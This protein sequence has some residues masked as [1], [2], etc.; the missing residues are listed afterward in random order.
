ML[1]LSGLVDAM[2]QEKPV[3]YYVFMD[4]TSKITF[5]QI[6]GSLRPALLADTEASPVDPHVRIFTD[7]SKM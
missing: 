1:D 7:V 3:L 4:Y 6:T 5:F 2:Y